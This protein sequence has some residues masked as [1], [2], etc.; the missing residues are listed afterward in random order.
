MK[1]SILSLIALMLF[2]LM[3]FA[4]HIKVALTSGKTY[5]Q[6]QADIDYAYDS[7]TVLFSGRGSL[8]FDLYCLY[9]MGVKASE[10]YKS[11]VEVETS[12]VWETRTIY[13]SGDNAREI[14][15]AGIFDSYYQSGC[16]YVRNVKW[17]LGVTPSAE[18]IYNTVDNADGT[19][20][21]SG[22]KVAISGSITL[23]SMLYGKTVTGVRKNALG[24]CNLISSIHIPASIT[25]VEDGTSFPYFVN[26]ITVASGN[27]MLHVSSNVL[28]D[29]HGVAIVSALQRAPSSSQTSLTLPSE[30]K[31][32]GAFSF[33]SRLS[34]YDAVIVPE[35]VT[36]ICSEAFAECWDVES[37]KLPSTLKHMGSHALF[38]VDSD[39]DNTWSYSI[40][41]DIPSLSFLCEVDTDPYGWRDTPLHGG[42]D[43][44]HGSDIYCYLAG[45]KTT[46][47]IQG[48]LAVE[49][50]TEKIGH[51]SL[52]RVASTYKIP[53]TVK[54]VSSS[55][56]LGHGTYYFSGD[57]PSF[58]TTR[59]G[60]YNSVGGIIYVEANA[61]GWGD[62]PGKWNSIST[63][64]YFSKP[65]TMVFDANGGVVSE[66]SKRIESE[67][68]YNNLPVPTRYGYTFAGWFTK[69]EGGHAVSSSSIAADGTVYAHWNEKRFPVLF[70]VGAYGTRIGGGELSQSV[71]EGSCAVL[72]EV[73]ANVGCKFL[74]W[75][76]AAEGGV[77]VT[78]QTVVTKEA[79]YYA[80]WEKIDL[81]VNFVLGGSWD[82][83]STASGSGMIFSSADETAKGGLSV[84]LKTQDNCSTWIETTVEGEMWVSFDWKTSCEKYGDLEL[85]RIEFSI[86]GQ[87]LEWL[88]GKSGW[89][90]MM[91]AVRGEGTHAI[92]FTYVKDE[93]EY[94]GEDCA[95][96][97]NVVMTPKTAVAS[98]VIHLAATYE[99][100]TTPCV[101]T[102][103]TVG[104]AIRYRFDYYGD[105]SEWF[106]YTGPF[107][108]SGTTKV[109]A[110]ATKQDYYDSESVSASCERTKPWTL[111]E[112][113]NAPHLD[114]V[115]GGDGDWC[116][117]TN[118]T[119]DGVAA[120]RS[121]EIGD[122]E[123]S[124]VKVQMLGPGTIS[125]WW[126][127]DSEYY[128]KTLLDYATFK[129]DGV[130][131]G[132]IGG[133]SD[134]TQVTH[135][136]SG[137]G[138]H[139]YLWTYTKNAQTAMGE[140]CAW[141]DEFVWTP[142]TTGGVVIPSTV[143][144]CKEFAIDTDW[145]DEE[146]DA[147]FGS[148]T[149]EKFEKRYGADLTAALL[150]STGKSDVHGNDRSVW[151]DNVMGTDPTDKASEF[152]TFVTMEGGF[153]TVTW[154]PDLGV[155]REYKVWGRESLTGGD[156]EWP[157]NALHRFFKVTVE[158]P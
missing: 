105:E 67:S 156:W 82:E 62:V 146:L 41:V 114:L 68:D 130:E 4:E 33:Y 2:P 83:G 7:V 44:Y 50:G 102:T 128:K 136:V 63:S 143:S 38:A 30:I 61:Q 119:H 121:G 152:K 151:Q 132:K 154:E 85:D 54:S 86:D 127:A 96:V 53:S 148:G 49:E 69:R 153:P 138:L 115:T 112:C 81:G 157:T 60:Y 73:Q 101:I 46:I 116:R 70:V 94:M 14:R 12:G 36:N 133:A 66:T 131:I 124:W 89:T 15:F 158:M 40:P 141:L 65:F 92:R 45:V 28:I 47:P 147:K 137:D 88:D 95:W 1:N 56:F 64:Y 10:N 52:T 79:T 125:F 23:P 118:T 77:R 104:A 78:D 135:D 145:K 150:K 22:Y 48:T 126:K 71:Q 120:I 155:L 26:T 106:D 109:I 97:A 3:S 74:G 110:Y 19:V 55:L 91:F 99:T 42:D 140:D 144:G 29:R 76:T 51:Y 107:E 80:H 113:V 18:D 98:P 129:V 93:S 108:I 25:N 8:T 123:Q 90:N 37:I 5:F 75:F 20:S 17:Q 24:D 134:W 100:E 16:G 59:H 34:L 32:I 43:D 35:G 13:F 72:P 31:E 58:R 11:V 6:E 39:D 21:I 139:T 149:R 142:D 84:R 9:G 27:K 117:T 122:G 111:A 103:D 87:R 57:A